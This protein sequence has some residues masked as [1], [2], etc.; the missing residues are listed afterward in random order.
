MDSFTLFIP[1]PLVLALVCSSIRTSLV[2]LKM[3]F[4]KNMPN[5]QVSYTPAELYSRCWRFIGI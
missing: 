4:N 5:C 3:F 1:T 2:I